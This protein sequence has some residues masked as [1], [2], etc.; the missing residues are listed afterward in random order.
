MTTAPDGSPVE[1]YLRF[2]PAGEAERVHDAIPGGAAI[3]ELG[4]GVGRITHELLR[5]GHPLVAVDESSE[6]LGH[7]HGAETVEARIEALD[8]GRRFPC[9]LLASHLVNTSDV[10]QRQAFLAA[11]ARHVAAD[12]KVLIERHPPAWAPEE[13]VRGTMGDVTIALEEVR[14]EP[15]L[16]SATVRYEAEGQTWRHRFDAHVLDDEALDLELRAAGLHLARVLD[17]RG[18]WVDA[19][20]ILDDIVAA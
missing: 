19:A 7:V 20:P 11:C 10:R 2:P 5:L 13:G 18:A 14:S 17:E 9:V 15:P 8:L 3:L 4:C 12:G 1:L 6:M 16:V